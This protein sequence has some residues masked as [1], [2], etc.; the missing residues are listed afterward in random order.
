MQEKFSILRE[1][2]R[3][4]STLVT[5]ITRVGEILARERFRPKVAKDHLLLN[6]LLY[7]S[8]FSKANPVPNATDKSGF[9]AV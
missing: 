4:C 1:L 3:E 2:F 8:I 9:S 7:K 6:D 5:T